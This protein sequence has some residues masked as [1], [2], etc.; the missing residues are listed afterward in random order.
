MCRRDALHRRNLGLV[1][2]TG[3]A[4]YHRPYRS[5]TRQPLAAIAHVTT[6]G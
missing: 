1:G 6:S 4:G 3:L 2:G 5:S